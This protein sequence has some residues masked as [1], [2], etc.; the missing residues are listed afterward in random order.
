MSNSDQKSLAVYLPN[1][2]AALD[3]VQHLEKVEN[4]SI[5]FVTTE[6]PAHAP[7]ANYHLGPA[8][9]TQILVSGASMIAAVFG[10]A[11]AVVN[12]VSSRKK[13][14]SSSPGPVVVV[15]E[16]IVIAVS[17]KTPRE[18]ADSIHALDPKA[19]QV[20]EKP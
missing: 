11:T 12:W 19:V 14:Y 15:N 20:R 2:E 13:D 3:V 7:G 8:E 10:L 6:G 9:L 18:L 16:T 1:M 5:R 17:G 4:L